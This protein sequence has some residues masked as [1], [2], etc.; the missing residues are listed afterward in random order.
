MVSVDEEQVIDE[1]D[2]VIDVDATE[3]PTG[4][5]IDENAEL[6]TTVRA[7]ITSSYE[8]TAKWTSRTQRRQP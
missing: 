3:V 8:Y 5:S 2:S 1:A 6:I 4:D 7:A